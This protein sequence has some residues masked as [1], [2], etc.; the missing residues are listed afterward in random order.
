MLD[1][2]IVPPQVHVGV[3]VLVMIAALAAVVVTGLQV[4][5]GQGS[6]RTTRLVFIA[7][8]LA[9]MLQILIGVKLLD[10]GFGA[11]QLFIHYV[12]GLGA[13]FF[14]LLYYWLKPNNVRTEGRL[15]FGMSVLAFLFV[16]QTYFI[17]QSFA[18]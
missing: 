17:G 13:F 2:V 7:A 11:V 5:K 9:L 12:G 3:G 10:Q 6:N 4:R 16:L 18:S 14:F 15:A 8:Q 1:A